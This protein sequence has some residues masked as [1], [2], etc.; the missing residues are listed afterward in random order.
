MIDYVRNT[1]SIWS[2]WAD[3]MKVPMSQV[4]QGNQRRQELLP[5]FDERAQKKF[6]E[7]QKRVP[8]GELSLKE[9][10]FQRFSGQERPPS[11]VL[12]VKT[13]PHLFEWRSIADGPIANIEINLRGTRTFVVPESEVKEEVTL[14]EF[15]TP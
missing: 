8:L 3:T 10:Q 2:A 11:L 1:S 12:H 5:V 9:E 6:R 4:L 7:Q 15:G 14:V 13:F